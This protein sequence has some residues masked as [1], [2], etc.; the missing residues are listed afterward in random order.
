VHVDGD[1]AL[2][3]LVDTEREDR[4]AFRF[5]FDDQARIRSVSGMPAF[6]DETARSPA[7]AAAIVTRFADELAGRDRSRA[8]CCSRTMVRHP[9]PHL[10]SRRSR[11]GDRQ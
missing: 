1:H 7:E 11:A 4:F 3:V 2:T 10:G 6:P 9:A 8:S 5:A